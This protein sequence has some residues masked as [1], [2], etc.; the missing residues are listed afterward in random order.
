MSVCR[1]HEPKATH[2]YWSPVSVEDRIAKM[3]LVILRVPSEN[4]RGLFMNMSFT[5]CVN[6]VGLRY[7]CLIRNFILLALASCLSTGILALA[8][9]LSTGTYLPQQLIVFPLILRRVRRDSEV[10]AGIRQVSGGIRQGFGIR[11]DLGFFL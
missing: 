6:C 4:K 5:L 8:N 7:T 3:L 2:S 9:C 11:R 10:S 1:F